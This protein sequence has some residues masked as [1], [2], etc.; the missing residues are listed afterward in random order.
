MYSS[1]A[2]NT[3]YLTKYDLNKDFY[4][5]LASRD[6]TGKCTTLHDVIRGQYGGIVPEGYIAVKYWA[7]PKHLF[8]TLLLPGQHF[9]GSRILIP[10]KDPQSAV[11]WLNNIVYPLYVDWYEHTGD[12]HLHRSFA[13]TVKFDF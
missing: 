13:K 6:L 7:R 11:D 9:E 5:Y 10:C 1:S 2:S 4:D 3:T 12:N 8:D